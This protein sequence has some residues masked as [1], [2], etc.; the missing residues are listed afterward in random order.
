[1]TITYTNIS[2]C[3]NFQFFINY[4]F[5]ISEEG[6]LCEYFTLGEELVKRTRF[7]LF[8]WFFRRSNI[9]LFF[10]IGKEITLSTRTCN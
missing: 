5:T 6:T 8:H 3:I 10:V 7:A 9:I 2:R 1:M 4:L